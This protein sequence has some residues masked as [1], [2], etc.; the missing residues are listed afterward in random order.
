MTIAQQHGTQP[1]RVQSARSLPSSAGL[2]TLLGLLAVAVTATGSW[3][4]SFWGDEAAS[5]MSSER[6]WRSLWH[7]ITHV[8]GVHATYYALMHVWIRCFGT[9]PFSMRFPS[10]I[11]I[12]IVVAGTVVLIRMFDGSK[13]LQ[14]LVGCATMLVPRL[15]YQ[16]EE[17]RAYA[18][19]AAIATWIVVAAIATIRGHVR[20]R[21]GWIFVGALLAIGTYFFMFVGL[22]AVVVA[23]LVLTLAPAD[24]RRRQLVRWCLVTVVV[25][26]ACSPVLI[27]GLSERSQVAFLADRTT[28][29]PYSLW[30]TTWF[31]NP[32]VAAV[33]WPLV[34]LALAAAAL[35]WRARARGLV[36]IVWTA[37]VWGFLPGAILVGANPIVHD[38]SARYMTFAAPAVGILAGTGI[39]RLFR[40]R[41][42]FGVIAIVVSAAVVVPTWAAIRTPTAY[43]ASDWGIVSRMVH[44]RAHRGD[45]VLFDVTVRPSRRMLLAMRTYPKDYA[46]LGEVQ[47]TTPFWANTSWDDKALTVDQAVAAGRVT[48]DHLWLLQD[49]HGGVVDHEG[50]SSLEHDGYHVVTRLRAPTSELVEFGR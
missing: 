39:D 20:P 12:G 24:E 21:L 7:E 30:I 6:S 2:P 36:S 48:A 11:A 25:I 28:T 18:I 16:G 29:D 5:V 32:R 22:M 40:W 33:A 14:L 13:R 34:A 35:A 26:V 50:E 1:I 15:S 44:Q 43:N 19:D 46:G 8:D 47:V 41:R 37:V 10:A 3:I 27:L 9:S 23:V 31:N 42:W 17:A 38:F 49:A 45:E 4:A